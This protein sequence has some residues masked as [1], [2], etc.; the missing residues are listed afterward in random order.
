MIIHIL[1]VHHDLPV[2]HISGGLTLILRITSR[3]ERAQI[4]HAQGVGTAEVA[5]ASHTLAIFQ[6]M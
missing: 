3:V 6:L 4:Q 2:K 5:L 1:S